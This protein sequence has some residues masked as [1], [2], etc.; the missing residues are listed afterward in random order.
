MRIWRYRGFGRGFGYRI[1]FKR[2]KRQKRL[3]TALM[4]GL[5]FLLL[6]YAFSL[7]NQRIKPTILSMAE[8]RARYIATAAINRVIY[9]QINEQNLKY[10]DLITFQTNHEGQITA[11]Q[12]NIIK[13]NQLKS[14]IAIRVQQEIFSIDSTLINIRVGNVI[15][16]EVLS[17]W[18]PKIPIRLMP[19]GSAQT[20]FTSSFEAAGINQTK[21]EIS[22]VVK[23]RVKVLLP[24]MNSSAEV[25]TTVP[26][27]QTIIVGIVPHQYINVEGS[28]I[29][30]YP[31][32]K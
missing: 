12:A 20:D 30:P 23:G 17:G 8:V 7:F 32:E 25:T 22:L 29:V 21:H 9:E 5:V 15:N 6:L 14:D 19:I 18:G 16:S 31:G 28:D 27:A 4:I 1:R 10:E 13:M 26:V 3:S 11:L 2:Q 24:M